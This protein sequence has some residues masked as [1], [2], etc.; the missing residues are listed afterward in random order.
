MIAARRSLSTPILLGVLL[1]ALISCAAEPSEDVGSVGSAQTDPNDPR[2]D[3]YAPEPGHPTAAEKTAFIAANAPA[4][5]EAEQTYGVPAA[6]I[7]AMAAVEGGYGFTRITQ[8]ANNS[9]GYKYTSAAAAGGRAS[10][11]LSCQPSWDVGNRYIAFADLRDGILFV[12]RKLATRADWANY[13][14]A[15]DRYRAERAAGVDVVTAVDRWVDGIADAGY[16]YDPPKYK[17]T[18]KGVMAGANLY[19]YS[20]AP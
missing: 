9:F 4:A 20:R 11:T 12:A 16:N 14:A 3:C 2:W 5:K 19:A 15:T 8:L 10:Y 6:A 17:R 13:K 1:G 7:L 18:I